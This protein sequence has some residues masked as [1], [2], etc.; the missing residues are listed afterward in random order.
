MC[1]ILFI[2]KIQYNNDNSHPGEFGSHELSLFQLAG[3]QHVLGAL[4]VDVTV[5]RVEGLGLVQTTHSTQHV[6]HVL[7][8]AGRGVEVMVVLKVSTAVRMR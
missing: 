2:A 8:V 7:V 6:A 1:G 4:A 3:S 5:R